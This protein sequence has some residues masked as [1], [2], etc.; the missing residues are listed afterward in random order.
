[1]NRIAIAARE[2]PLKN[3]IGRLYIPPHLFLSQEDDNDVRDN[4]N[5]DFR[6]VPTHPMLSNANH[7]T[8]QP[9]V[10]TRKYL[11]MRSRLTGE[12]FA[13]I[14]DDNLRISDSQKFEVSAYSQD[15]L[16]GE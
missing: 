3:L 4:G 15:R 7:L 10:S 6:S 9:K 11:M 13:Y 16:I 2:H 14:F 5:R 12:F 8:I 1:M